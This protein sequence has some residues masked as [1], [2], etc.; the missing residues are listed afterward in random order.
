MQHRDDQ[1]ERAQREQALL[2]KLKSAE[3]KT[4]GALER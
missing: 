1:E 4:R 3:E 2:E